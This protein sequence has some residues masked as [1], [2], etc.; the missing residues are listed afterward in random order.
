MIKKK[1]IEVLNKEFKICS[2]CRDDLISSGYSEKKVMK[3]SDEKM[4]YIANRLGE[5]LMENY[6]IS[7]EI[8]VDDILKNKN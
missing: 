7:L 6:W 4:N 2:L 1:K 5:T 8:I 3:L